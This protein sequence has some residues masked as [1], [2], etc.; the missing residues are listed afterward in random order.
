[1]CF[2]N[3]KIV[4]DII[5]EF[6]YAL[7]KDDSRVVLSDGSEPIKPKNSIYKFIIDALEGD[8]ISGKSGSDQLTFLQGYF[9]E[10]NTEDIANALKVVNHE[11]DKPK[12]QAP[13]VDDGNNPKKEKSKF[14]EVNE[15]KT[16]KSGLYKLKLNNIYQSGGVYLPNGG[17]KEVYVYISNIETRK[18]LYLFED[19]KIIKD[20]MG[21]KYKFNESGDVSG[22]NKDIYIT[23]LP[24][25]ISKKELVDNIKAINFKDKNPIE[26]KGNGI[27]IKKIEKINSVYL[28]KL[29]SLS[30]DDIKKIEKTTPFK[31]S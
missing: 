18:A 5:N 31:N 28:A 22:V 2:G 13:K 11:K 27:T 19:Y 1:M 16:S 3:N 24:G 6:D 20:K 10:E 25:T 15:I 4:I 23:R 17:D 30:E 8:K 12:E 7:K 14:T 26:F 9:G 21:S 29:P